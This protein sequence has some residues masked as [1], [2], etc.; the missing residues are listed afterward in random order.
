MPSIQLMPEDFLQFMLNEQFTAT[1]SDMAKSIQSPIKLQEAFLYIDRP[2]LAS[3]QGFATVNVANSNET[4]TVLQ[5]GNFFG[6]D[7]SCGDRWLCKS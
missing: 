2:A 4:V 5:N 7:C 6:T 3:T 1:M